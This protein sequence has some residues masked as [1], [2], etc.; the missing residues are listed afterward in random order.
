MISVTQNAHQTHAHT[1]IICSFPPPPHLHFLSHSSSFSL[2]SWK[3]S[4]EFCGLA[5]GLWRVSA[6]VII[7]EFNFGFLLF[8]DIHIHKFNIFIYLFICVSFLLFLLHLHLHVLWFAR[9]LIPRCVC[10][11]LF[12]DDDTSCYRIHN[13]ATQ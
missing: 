3:F 6:F 8:D 5:V 11:C 10:V 13:K 1:T 9:I 12:C 4:F 7:C 2:S